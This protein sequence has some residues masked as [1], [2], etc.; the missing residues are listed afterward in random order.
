MALTKKEAVSMYMKTCNAAHL[1][2]IALGRPMPKTTWEKEKKRGAVAV[3]VEIHAYG[4]A[5]V[6]TTD[7]GARALDDLMGMPHP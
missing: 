1:M 6:E 3:R 7:E 4:D 5:S 2:S